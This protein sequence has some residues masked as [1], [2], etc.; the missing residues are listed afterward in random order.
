M[1]I[2]AMLRKHPEIATKCLTEPLAKPFFLACQEQE[3]VNGGKINRAFS[4]L[5]LT[6]LEINC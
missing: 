1:T 2:Q 3:C 4:L 5:V 6:T